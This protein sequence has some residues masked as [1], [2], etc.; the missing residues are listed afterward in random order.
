[1]LND[2]HVR[3]KCLLHEKRIVSGHFFQTTV[4]FLA[5]ECY[6]MAAI[7]MS[8]RRVFELNN[9]PIGQGMQIFL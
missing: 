3:Y 5:T 1:M 7:S 2:F 4:F 6:F 9:V 8:Q